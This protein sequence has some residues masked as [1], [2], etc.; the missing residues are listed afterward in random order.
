ME[1]GK[2]VNAFVTITEFLKGGWPGAGGVRKV[3]M[4]KEDNYEQQLWPVLYSL[5][6]DIGTTT[7]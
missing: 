4:K 3:G 7:H 5:L 2:R 6:F 1:N